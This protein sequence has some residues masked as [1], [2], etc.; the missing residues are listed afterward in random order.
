MI[1]EQKVAFS[2]FEFIRT[3]FALALTTFIVAFVFTTASPL[4]PEGK[5]SGERK[6]PTFHLPRWAT[7]Y[8]QPDQNWYCFERNFAETAERRGGACMGLYER[9]D[10]IFEKKLKTGSWKL[11]VA[12]NRN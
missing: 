4:K 1:N 10:A 3:H 5:R 6:W 12:L 8:V 2:M 9:Y 11:S 7:S